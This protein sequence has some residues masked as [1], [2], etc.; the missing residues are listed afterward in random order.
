MK[1]DVD[2]ARQRLSVAAF[3]ALYLALLLLPIPMYAVFLVGTQGS[4]AALST[5]SAEGSLSMVLALLVLFTAHELIHVG[6]FWSGGVDWRHISLAMDKSSLSLGIDVSMRIPVKLWRIALLA[7][8]VL[9]SAML[10]AIGWHEGV[11]SAAWLLLAFSTSGCA[12]DIAV[13]ISLRG[14]PADT[15]VY[16]GFTVEQERLAICPT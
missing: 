4:M 1:S 10:V 11:H 5:L 13:F 15:R 6:V 3:N 2:I 9:L 7:P 12:Y 14:Y 8:L 16:P